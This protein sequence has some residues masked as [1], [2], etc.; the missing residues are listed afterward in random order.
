[1]HHPRR[2]LCRALQKE[3]ERLRDA[4]SQSQLSLEETR[5][6]RDQLSTSQHELENEKSQHLARLGQLT[7]EN[8][9][10]KELLSAKGIQIPLTWSLGASG[11]ALVLGLIAGVAWLDNRIR[12]RHGGFR[13][14]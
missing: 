5:D 11:V 10:I 14:Y 7:E 1:M 3:V 9:E 2:L 6:K 8:Q 12:K 13:I 4:L